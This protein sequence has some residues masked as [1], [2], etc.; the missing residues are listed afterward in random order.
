MFVFSNTETI[1]ST[2]V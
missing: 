2:L 1:T